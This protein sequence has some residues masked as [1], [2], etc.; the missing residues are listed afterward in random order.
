MND[1]IVQ[2]DEKRKRIK[3]TRR[4][5]ILTRLG[6]GAAV[7]AGI[8]VFLLLFQ[9]RDIR[10][11]GND[12]LTDSEVSRY[13]REQGGDGNSLVLLLSTKLG[14]YPEPPTVESMEFH[15]VNPWTIRVDVKEK[16]PA[17]YARRDEEYV[18][19][20]NEGMV[21][22]VT[23]SQ[24]DGLSL[25]EGF[26]VSKAEKGKKLTV[27][28]SSVFEYIVRIQEILGRSGV[29][30][31]R[32]VCDGENLTLYFGNIC[33]ELGSGDPQEKAAQLP[34]ILEKLEGQSGTL[35]LEHYGELTETFRFEKSETTEESNT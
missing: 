32:I 2:R 30:P 33:A 1:Q 29:S 9:L 8:I 22:G 12:F 5:Q 35:H 18:Y 21:L 26:D 28:D 3:R 20:D 6:T 14:D 24:R 25:V 4:R 27:Q 16:S 7:I 15:M 10:V 11:R 34:A 17:G 31:D 23:D 13:I 19:F